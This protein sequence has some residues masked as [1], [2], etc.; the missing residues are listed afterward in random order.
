MSR[1]SG[2]PLGGGGG[3]LGGGGHQLGVVGVHGCWHS[4][5]SG[6]QGWLGFSRVKDVVGIQGSGGCTGW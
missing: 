4:R 1:G 6:V 2:G 3:P 5:G